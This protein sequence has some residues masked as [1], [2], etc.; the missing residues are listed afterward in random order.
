MARQEG[1]AEAKSANIAIVS[2][3]GDTYNF[4]AK[5]AESLCSLYFD[6]CNFLT[7]Y[8]G[9]NCSIPPSKKSPNLAAFP[10]CLVIRRVVET[11]YL[12]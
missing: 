11:A 2:D 12:K 6:M 1:K 4:G 5:V 3:T 10:P 9:Q 8:A 7:T